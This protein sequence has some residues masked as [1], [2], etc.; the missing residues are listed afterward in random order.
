MLLALVLVL[1][2]NNLVLAD[3]VTDYLTT[4]LADGPEYNYDLG[5]EQTLS[6][7]VTVPPYATFVSLPGKESALAEHGEILGRIT[8]KLVQENKREVNQTW[9]ED[10]SDDLLSGIEEFYTIEQ[11]KWTLRANV[12][13]QTT[14]ETNTPTNLAENTEIFYEFSSGHT[15]LASSSAWK[16]YLGE[17][18]ELTFNIQ[19]ESVEEVGFVMVG[20]DAN[21]YLNNWEQ[22]PAGNYDLSVTFTISAAE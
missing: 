14:V 17:N 18:E 12:P 5:Q 7:Q 16:T 1:G 22:L 10:P 11:Y 13:T 20:M 6:T 21:D 4:P 8:P 3:W 15:D 2:F 9:L 19:D